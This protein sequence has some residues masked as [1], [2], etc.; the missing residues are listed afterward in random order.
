MSKMW[1]LQSKCVVLVNIYVKMRC[2]RVDVSTS[3]FLRVFHMS[4]ALRDMTT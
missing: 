1:I 4:C 3:V 2:L